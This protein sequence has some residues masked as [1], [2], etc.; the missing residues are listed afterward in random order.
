MGS[1]F[2][3]FY[4]G[5]KIRETVTEK[6]L[7]IFLRILLSDIRIL[8]SMYQEFLVCTTLC[9]VKREPLKV[10]NRPLPGKEPSVA[11]PRVPL[12][13]ST[14]DTKRLHRLKQQTY[15]GKLRQQEDTHACTYVYVV[16]EPG[17]RVPRPPRRQPDAPR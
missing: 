2:Y 10:C 17:H 13:K 1:F 8:V 5:S 6:A 11:P 9:D 12:R 4:F 14:L 16:S 7:M 3:W 15:K